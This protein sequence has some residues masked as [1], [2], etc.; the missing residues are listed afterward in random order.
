MGMA[1]N[2]LKRHFWMKVSG[3]SMHLLQVIPDMTDG[4]KSHNLSLL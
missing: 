3:F 1:N 2:I 4:N